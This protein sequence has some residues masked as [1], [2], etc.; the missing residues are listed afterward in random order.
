MRHRTEGGASAK[1]GF[2]KSVALPYTG[3]VI[4]VCPN[5]GARYRLSDAVMSR[6]ARLRCAECDHRW[7]PAP[8]EPAMGAQNAPPS[9]PP[10]PPP[11][12]IRR[13]VTEADEEAAFAA[14]QAQVQ[15]RW[16]PTTSAA[17]AIAGG[18][19]DTPGNDRDPENP[20]TDR[21]DHGRVSPHGRS[22][23]YIRWLV[24]GMAGIA[25]SVAAAGLWLGQ[26]DR[27]AVPW[28][29]PLIERLQAPSPLR[30]AVAGRATSLPSGHRL[31][32]ITGSIRNDSTR[33]VPVP[34]LRASL[35]G[36]A[37]VALRWTMA[38][39]VVALL[40]GQQ[41]EFS[42]TVTG[43]PAEASVLTV[44]TGPLFSSY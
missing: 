11:A 24:A 19:D 12:P 33:T 39:P 16:Q 17:A 37:G 9:P 31:L 22:G 43:F 21:D 30:L 7:V 1:T 44:R 18:F 40:P 42:G 2:R 4:V 36:P 25:L 14:V 13:P 8:A 15:S 35:A 28:A 23:E 32:E 10:S 34:S 20:D 26:L 6:R 27:A 38:P 3:M 41:V 29:G 5:C